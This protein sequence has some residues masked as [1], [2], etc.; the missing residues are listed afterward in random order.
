VPGLDLQCYPPGEVTER[1]VPLPVPVLTLLAATPGCMHCAPSTPTPTTDSNCFHPHRHAHL[2]LPHVSYTTSARSTFQSLNR[3][4]SCCHV[5]LQG[6]LCTT[7]CR[8][9]AA[10]GQHDTGQDRRSRARQGQQGKTAGLI[11]HRLQGAR[12]SALPLLLPDNGLCA[13]GPPPSAQLLSKT[14]KLAAASYCCWSCAGT[15]N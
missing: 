4:F 12:H 11:S 13:Q 7:T 9:G 1:R 10:Q 15:C 8:Q 5:V 6:R 14:H 3:S 2:L